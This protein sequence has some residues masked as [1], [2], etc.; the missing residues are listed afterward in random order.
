MQRFL[1]PGNYLLGASPIGG[2]K[3]LELLE[4]MPHSVLQTKVRVATQS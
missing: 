3:P 4:G 1:Q 2:G